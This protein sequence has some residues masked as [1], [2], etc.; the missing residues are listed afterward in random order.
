MDDDVWYFAERKGRKGLIPSNYVA[1]TD[2]R[3]IKYFVFD[4]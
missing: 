2:N 1:M 3:Y 4:Q